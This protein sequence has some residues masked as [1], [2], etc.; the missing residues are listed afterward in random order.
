MPSS[1]TAAAPSTVISVKREELPLVEHRLVKAGYLCDGADTRIG[2]CSSPTGMEPSMCCAEMC[3]WV[4]LCKYFSYNV[5]TKQCWWS[6]TLPTRDSTPSL[7]HRQPR[8]RHASPAPSLR[9][10]CLLTRSSR[11]R[12]P[13]RTAT[14]A[15][16]AG[17]STRAR[18]SAR[19]AG[20]RPRPRYR[21]TP[22]TRG[23]PTSAGS[24]CG[25]GQSAPRQTPSSGAGSPPRWRS[26]PPSASPMR[27]ATSLFTATPCL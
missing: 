5:E 17:G 22:S 1:D 9:R 14:T 12:R 25:S 23:T 19:R 3:W 16:R 21:C 11:P 8:A 2:Y 18:R 7:L 26:A 4:P 15:R 27:S 24:W 6:R 20:R 13:R 10:L